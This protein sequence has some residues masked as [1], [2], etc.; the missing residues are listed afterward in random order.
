MNPPQFAGSDDASGAPSPADTA[1]HQRPA[2][3]RF[4]GFTF[5]RLQSGQGTADVTLEWHDGT[6]YLGRSEGVSSA[7]AD[8]RL[9]AD[10]TLRAIAQ[11]TR[12]PGGFELV[13]V[14]SLRAFDSNVV[15]VSVVG[16]RDGKAQQLLG[17]RIAEGDLLRSAVLATLQA[18]NRVMHPGE[19]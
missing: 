5:Q 10:A 11:F 18:T 6:R 9:A 12:Q 2:R 8:L 15:L 13:G 1:P 17:C 7:W 14:K 4:V 16:R 3:L 19:E